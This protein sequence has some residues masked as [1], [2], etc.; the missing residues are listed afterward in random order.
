[1]ASYDVTMLKVSEL[2]NTS[3]STANVCL[4]RSY[5]CVLNFIHLSAMGVAEIAKSTH[6]K[7]CP[8]TLDG[9]PIECVPA[10]KY[11]VIWIDMDL[12][13]KK[14]VHELV[15]K[16]IFKVV[17][18]YRNRL[19]LSLSSRKQIIQSTFLSVLDYGDIIY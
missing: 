7:G 3:H 17:F 12:T 19:C 18:F 1:M 15:K 9:S 2:F 10:Y 16:L 8:H 6:L 14:H 4:W 5:G 11:L 13:F